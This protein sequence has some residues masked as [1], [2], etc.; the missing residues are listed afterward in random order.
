MRNRRLPSRRRTVLA[1]A[2]VAAAIALSGCLAVVH[3]PPPPPPGVYSG[4]AFDTCDAPSTSTMSAWLNSPYR[5][6]GV[7]IGGANAACVNLSASWVSTVANQGWHLAP[8]YVGLQDPCVFQG[9]LATID[10]NQPL[11][12]GV[13]S[14]DNAV[15]KASANGLGAGTPIYFDMEAYNNSN[16]ELSLDRDRVHL[17]RGPPSST[18]GATSPATTPAQPRGSRMRPQPS[19]VRGPS[20]TTSGSRTGTAGRTSTETRTS[21]T[22]SGTT[23]SGCTSTPA[24][25]PSPGVASRWISTATS[26]TRS[27][28]ADPPSRRARHNGRPGRSTR[29]SSPLHRASDPTEALARVWPSQG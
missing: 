20:P 12:Q 18:A 17:T 15:Q 6:I 22:R 4:F 24:V 26:A 1:S 27:S 16:P 21:R 14:A 25:T 11:Q 9:G 13:A 10:P 7:Y 8:L 29:P 19:A 5:G 28:R 3:P 23:T 2:G